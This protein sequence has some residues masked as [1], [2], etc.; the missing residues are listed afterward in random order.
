MAT[1]T[2]YDWERLKRVCRYLKGSPRFNYVS[3]WQTRED[4]KLRL[5][6]DWANEA[7]SRKSHSGALLARGHLL[8][9]WCRRQPVVA[10][11]SGEAEVHSAVCGLSKLTGVSNV[12]KEMRG[13]C[14]GEPMEHAVDA[15][16][17]MSI[18]LRRGPGGMK[19]LDTKQLWVQEA[20]TEKRIREL[21]I[22]RE[23][24]PADTLESYSSAK[25]MQKHVKMMGCEVR[26][27]CCTVAGI[28]NELCLATEAL[29]QSET[30][31]IA[32]INHSIFFS[33]HF[34]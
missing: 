25:V 15:P 3:H 13:E 30:A 21:K 10:L 23:E 1:P 26:S 33:M 17:C 12:L 11:S 24:N 16:T 20:I 8:Q 28:F 32:E 4:V 7:K 9:H 5:L 19:H 29:P 14:W 18:L 6:T 34:L 31:I 2:E 27:T 22:N